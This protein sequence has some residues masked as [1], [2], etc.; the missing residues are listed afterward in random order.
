MKS[1]VPRIEVADHR[2]ST[3]MGGPDGEGHSSRPMV[4]RRM[5]AHSLPELLVAA[6]SGKVEVELAERGR[7]TVGIPQRED[8]VVRVMDLEQVTKDG[9]APGDVHLEEAIPE[10]LH[11][12]PPT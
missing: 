5:G 2:Y 12:E 4:M 6:F 8:G 3:R 9:R 7:E 10:V 1:A 11:L